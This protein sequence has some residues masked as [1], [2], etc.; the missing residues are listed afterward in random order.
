MATLGIDISKADFH[1]TL[2]LASGSTKHSFPNSQAGYRQLQRWLKNRKVSELHACM[3]ATGAYWSGLAEHL[4]AQGVSVSVVNPARVKSFGQSQLRRTKTD[5]VDSEIIAEF[6]KTQSPVLWEPPAKEILEIRALL[7]YREQ[8]IAER[9]RSRQVSSSISAAHVVAAQARQHIKQLDKLIDE[10][11]NHLR[12]L[13]AEAPSL[14]RA[15]R[16]L[17]TVPGIGLLSA[18]AILAHLPM[19]RLRNSKAA[20]AY[21]G[22]TPCERQSGTSVK[23]RPR[24][25]KIGNAQLRKALY[26]PALSAARGNSSLG[27]FAARLRAAGKKGKVVI[28]AVMRKLVTIAYA[29]LKAGMPFNPGLPA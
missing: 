25:S 16:L 27:A 17:E 10:L 6:C 24:L 5:R 18:A 2:L 20:A 12:T 13:V 19:T 4:H 11:E 29:I 14:S 8:L 23:G 22:L 9:I 28:A 21:A 15:T 3:E 26:M 1:A 7:T